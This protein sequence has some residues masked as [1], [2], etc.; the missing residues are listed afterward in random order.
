MQP[1]E[2]SDA[3]R[4][5]GM[6]T[7]W[8]RAAGVAIAIGAVAV[9]AAG[10]GGSSP[11]PSTTG[12]AAKPGNG[13]NAAYRFSACMR[14]HGVT[15]FP[16]PT[17]RSS[18]GHQSVTVRITPLISSSPQ[19]KTAQQACQSILPGPNI[20]AAQLAQQQH[21]REGA[22]LA[23]ARCLRAHGLSGFPDPNSQGQ[24]TLQMV[25]AA[26]IDLHA[27]DVLPAAKACIGVTHGIITGADVERA[28]NSGG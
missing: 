21:A 17:V 22:L 25:H 18:P 11:K 9:C 28:V 12:A 13:V 3:S 26:G 14:D 16:D 2:P 27:P 7:P 6:H 5:I 20:S 19:F 4:L 8:R 10:C 1:T 15:S 24:L 23:F